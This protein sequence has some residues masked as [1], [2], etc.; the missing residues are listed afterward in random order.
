MY[1]LND[2]YH[3]KTILLLIFIAIIFAGFNLV[4]VINSKTKID[5]EISDMDAKIQKL[6][7][8]NKKN[9]E[10]SKTLLNLEFIKKEAKRRLNLQEEGENL[11]IIKP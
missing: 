8:E 3:S 1:K 5:K 9:I 2:L 7:E 6:Q 4:K 11:I 10:D